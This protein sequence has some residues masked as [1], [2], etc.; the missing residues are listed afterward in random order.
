[1]KPGPGITRQASVGRGVR[2]ALPDDRGV[3]VVGGGVGTPRPAGRSH[4]IASAAAAT[5]SL[6][7][8]AGRLNHR[9]TM[10][11]EKTQHGWGGGPAR[12]AAFAFLCVHRVSVVNSVPAAS[13]RR[14]QTAAT[15]RYPGADWHAAGRKCSKQAAFGSLPRGSGPNGSR[16][17]CCRAEV[18]QTGAIWGA[19][20][21]KGA[22]REPFGSLPGGSGSN[23][24]GLGRCFMRKILK[25]NGLLFE[26]PLGTG[27]HS[28]G[29]PS[30]A[31]V[32]FACRGRPF[33][34]PGRQGAK[35]QGIRHGSGEPSGTASPG[36]K[37]AAEVAWPGASASW[38]PCV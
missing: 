37:D 3:R 7:V 1:M 15:A 14:S 11:T 13:G 26:S 30:A 19:V 8:P 22:G 38:R 5:P 9:D 29:V 4:A 31:P 27:P 25:M 17:A 35:P 23:G 20:A 10:N 34:T 28:G 24:S 12:G 33:L 21:R 6:Q 16:L 32:V 36:A 18:G 2:T